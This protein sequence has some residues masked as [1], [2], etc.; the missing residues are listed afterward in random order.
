M[1]PPMAGVGS[2]LLSGAAL[3]FLSK[4]RTARLKNLNNTANELYSEGA[5]PFILYHSNF[6]N[7]SRFWF[8]FSSFG[9]VT[10]LR[11][12]SWQRWTPSRAAP[13][14]LRGLQCTDFKN[15]ASSRTKNPS[16]PLYPKRGDVQDGSYSQIIIYCIYFFYIFRI[17]IRV[18]LTSF[19]E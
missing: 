2:D 14:I 15:D 6:E 11:A 16:S 17:K 7:F 12:P 3:R 1:N 5:F 10:D 19:E 18:N 8:I 4:P 9:L 13:K